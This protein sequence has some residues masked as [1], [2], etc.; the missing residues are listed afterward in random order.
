MRATFTGGISDTVDAR[1]SETIVRTPFGRDLYIACTE[2]GIVESR[3]VSRT[4]A[5][6]RQAT[7]ASDLLERALAEL[8]AYFERARMRFEV[9]LVLS[10]TAFQIDAWL[11]V[12]ALPFGTI[13]SYADVARAIGRPN[14]HRGV[15]A[16]LAKTP[17]A[18]FVPAH[19]VVG[20]DGRIRGAAPNSLR[21]RLLAFE[22]RPA[23]PL[24]RPESPGAEAARA[25]RR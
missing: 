6:V 2:A 15:A 20:A 23:G 1:V 21:C 19:R 10:G 9:P 5:K 12:A 17:L 22:A 3:F 14:A 11:A 4:R 16:A 13:A 24:T 7:T 18:L 8:D 25:W